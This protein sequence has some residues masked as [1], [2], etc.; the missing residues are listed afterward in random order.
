MMTNLAT[1]VAEIAEQGPA[2]MVAAIKKKT[3]APITTLLAAALETQIP[4][5]ITALLETAPDATAV[6]S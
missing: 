5:P 2:L 6:S 1:M 4:A 3:P